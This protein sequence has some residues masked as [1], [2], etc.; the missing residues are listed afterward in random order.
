MAT[1]AVTSLPREALG[2]RASFLLAYD[3]LAL[4]AGASSERSVVVAAVDVTGEVVAARRVFHGCAIVVGRHDMCGLRLPSHTVALR[5]AVALV[6]LGA[7]SSTVHLRDLATRQPFLTEDRQP[8]SAV[9]ADGP[10][11]AAV[12]EYA[13]WFI[14]S[15]ALVDGGAPR[16]GEDAWAALAPRGFV[17]RRPPVDA[18]R[19]AL[20]RAPSAR[21]RQTCITHLAPPLLLDASDPR[22][23]SWGELRL[24]LGLRKEKRWVSAERL[25]HGILLGRYSRCGVLVDAAE[26]TTSRVHALLTLLGGDVWI[27]DLAST[28]GVRREGVPVLAGILRDEDR[29]ALGSQVVLGW[30]RLHHAAA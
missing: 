8:S 26:S 25:E 19:Q 17:Q 13:L 4:L 3:R 6:Q 14:P 29:L 27:I 28:N 15:E 7:G 10:L 12:G 30:K 23:I 16:R 20:L 11:Y 1:L 5:H 24:E 9:T 21:L 18:P 2:P 22:E